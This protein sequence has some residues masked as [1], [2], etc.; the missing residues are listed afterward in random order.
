[1]GIVGEGDEDV[2]HGFEERTS[3]ETSD[4]GV[5]GSKGESASSSRFGVSVVDDLV[6]EPLD[7]GVEEG[8]S[9]DAGK[10]SESFAS[11]CSK[12]EI[13]VEYGVLEKGGRAKS[14]R[15]KVKEKEETKVHRRT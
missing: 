12:S 13:A 3:D 1:M 2:D 10:S 5:D 8:R 4:V 14:Q 6:D 11:G 9:A 7:R 15:G